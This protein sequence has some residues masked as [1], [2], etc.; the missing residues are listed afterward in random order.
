MH[1]NTLPITALPAW[2]KLNDLALLGISAKRLGNERGFALVAD[3]ALTSA[4]S[5]DVPVLLS[6]PHD[7]I[8]SAVTIEEHAKADGHFRELLDAA[9]GLVGDLAIH[10]FRNR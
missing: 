10:D 6:I 7:L 4:E 5:S 3:K 2:S 8:L 9:G 1:R